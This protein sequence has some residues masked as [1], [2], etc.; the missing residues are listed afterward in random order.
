[1]FDPETVLKSRIDFCLFLANVVNHCSCRPTLEFASEVLKRLSQTDCVSFH[2]A[3]SEILHPTSNAESFCRSDGEESI[4]DALHYSANEK[5]FCD[6]VLHAMPDGFSE[7]RILAEHVCK[8]TRESA[9][10]RHT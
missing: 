9:L 4:A 6:P 5:P 3:I 2:A 10:E 1:M 8:A 7:C